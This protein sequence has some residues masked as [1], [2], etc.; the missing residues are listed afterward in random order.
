MKEAV[1]QTVEINTLEVG[2]E[3]VLLKLKPIGG[4]PRY[5]EMTLIEWQNL[6]KPVPGDTLYLRFTLP[7]DETGNTKSELS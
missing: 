5:W 3:W 4:Q 6:N 1:F 7:P 2:T